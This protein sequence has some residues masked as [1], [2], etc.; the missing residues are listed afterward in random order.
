MKFFYR[1]TRKSFEIFFKT[2]Y[3][4]QTF[5]LENIPKGGCIIAPNHASFFDPPLVG[6]SYSEEIHYMARFSLF[7]H[8]PFGYIITQLNAL[9]IYGNEHDRAI[10]RKIESLILE[11][12]KVVIFPEGNR[13]L[14]GELQRLERG[15]ALIAQRT[16]CPIVPVYLAGTFQIWPKTNKIPH[17]KGHTSCRFGP[18]IYPDKYANLDKKGAI[19][20]MTNDLDLALHSLKKKSI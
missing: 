13:T 12:E 16:R 19:Q 7:H 11:G 9:P 15:V 2:F 20:A 14:D 1:I 5:G 17:L 18:A 8:Q 3:G 10:I 6:A 4:H